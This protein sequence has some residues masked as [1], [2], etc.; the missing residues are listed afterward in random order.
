MKYGCSALV[1]PTVPTK[2]PSPKT[3][4]F[5]PPCSR[6]V[7]WT[8]HQLPSPTPIPQ[9]DG[10]A[11]DPDP[12][13][14]PGP[15]GPDDPGPVGPEDPGPVEPEDHGPEHECPQILYNLLMI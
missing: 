11:T 15:V 3:P 13:Y 10:E 1:S 9:L 5:T 6:H 7:A 8:K 12:R 2:S 14:D 4:A